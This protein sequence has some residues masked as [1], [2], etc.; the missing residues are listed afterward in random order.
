MAA[1][2][3]AATPAM[4]QSHRKTIVGVDQVRFEPLTQRVPVIARLVSRRNGYV[5]A[6]VDG[7][8]EK[9]NVAV[10]DH[11]RKGDVLAVVDVKS[12]KARRLVLEAEL[13]GARAELQSVKTE[14]VLTRQNMER[15]RNLKKTG[16]FN[17]SLYETTQQ[18]FARAEA[19][20]M[21]SKAVIAAKIAAI[22]V[23]DLEIARGKIISPYDGIVV[24]RKTEQG[25]YLRPGDPV[26]K[27]IGDG[28]LEIE[29]DVPSLR[30]AGLEKGTIVKAVL[31]DGVKFTAKMRASLPVENP[32]TRTRA[33]RFVPDWPK[34]ITRLA[35]AQTVTIYLPIAAPRNI[36]TVHKDAIINKEGK[37]YVFIVDQGKAVS[38][39]V[40]LGVATGGRIEVLAGLKAG[41][42][43]V[44]RGNERLRPGTAVE[45]SKGT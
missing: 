45:I 14:L 33:V 24:E 15:Q 13:A 6:L 5:A 43:A 28:M 10:G 35:H 17:R 8:V 21:R 25:S 26:V 19:A 3:L 34:N 38:R 40:R 1:V 29:A 16:A 42:K 4:A 30:L 20:I 9:V 22:A 36:V 18:K 2:L 23:L 31:D 12:R 44:V 27:L 7:G 39:P 37:N 32:R 41:D 11:V